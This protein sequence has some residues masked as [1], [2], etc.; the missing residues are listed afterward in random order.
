MFASYDAGFSSEQSELIRELSANGS[1]SF[2]WVATRTPYDLL[3]APEAATYLCTYENKP[4]MMT[5][6]A[7]ILSGNIPVTA[8]LPVTIGD[9]PRANAGE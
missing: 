2:V 4:A 3:I 9:Y 6:L 7:G 8:K 1:Y 5:A